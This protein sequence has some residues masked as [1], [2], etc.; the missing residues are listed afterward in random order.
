MGS[1]ALSTY[2]T[3]KTAGRHARTLKKGNLF[4]DTTV[5]RFGIPPS[6]QRRMY[7]KQKGGFLPFLKKPMHTK[8]AGVAGGINSFAHL[9]TGQG[10]GKGKKK[11]KICRRRR[12]T[13]TR[14]R[15]AR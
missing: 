8:A 6:M 15:N 12:R 7:N 1:V 2:D 14:K 13:P 9:L 10:K 11:R 5:N 4:R 3:L